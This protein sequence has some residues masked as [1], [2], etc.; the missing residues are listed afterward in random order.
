MKLHPLQGA[1]GDKQLSICLVR[2]N[3]AARANSLLRRLLYVLSTSGCITC[4]RGSPAGPRGR[5]AATAS[6]ATADPWRT[7]SCSGVLLMNVAPL[8]S[9]RATCA[10]GIATML[11][12]LL[13]ACR[14]RCVRVPASEW[15]ALL[16]CCRGPFEMT[17]S[18]VDPCMKG[19]QRPVDKSRHL[20]CPWIPLLQ[21][22]QQH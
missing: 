1:D 8:G 7:Y 5:V 14:C 11:H 19:Q 21:R 6:L 20:I 13:C 18:Q 3:R 10:P 17:W 12:R 15:E 4:E 22:L 2:H 16:V 9:C